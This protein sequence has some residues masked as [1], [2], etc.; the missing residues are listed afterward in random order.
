MWPS[1]GPDEAA[2]R[3]FQLNGY[4]VIA[5]NRAGLTWWAVSDLGAAELQQLQGL[6]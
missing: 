6:L 3:A 4:N 5:W 1:P 2:S